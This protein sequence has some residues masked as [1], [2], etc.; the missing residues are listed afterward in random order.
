[1]T[2][3]F[4]TGSLHFIGYMKKKLFHTLNKVIYMLIN[5]VLIY[6][7]NHKLIIRKGLSLLHM[8]LPY[9]LYTIE[10]WQNL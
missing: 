3:F 10:K 6:S 8:A 2:L 4:I 7:E 5:Q 9:T 1:M